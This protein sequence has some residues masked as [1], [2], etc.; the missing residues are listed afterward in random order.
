MRPR[1]FRQRQ[2][3]AQLFVLLS[4]FSE[5]FVSAKWR[6]YKGIFGSSRLL[7]EGFRAVARSAT[8]FFCQTKFTKR[9]KFEILNGKLI[10]KR[11]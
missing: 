3:N 11:F 2:Q 10:Y 6:I 7:R 1:Y 5:N 9:D 8:V 4:F